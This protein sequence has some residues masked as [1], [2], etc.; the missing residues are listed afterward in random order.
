MKHMGMFGKGLEV[1][2][3]WILIKIGSLVNLILKNN[4]L[5]IQLDH[6]IGSDKNGC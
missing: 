1:A 4:K 3:P 5:K 2:P 6:M